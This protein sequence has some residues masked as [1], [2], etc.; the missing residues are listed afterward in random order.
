[1]ALM[2]V[3]LPVFG[4]F[5]RGADPLQLFRSGDSLRGLSAA[6]AV[7]AAVNLFTLGL[8]LL[9]AG[10]RQ[11][12]LRTSPLARRGVLAR[13]GAVNLML[14]GVAAI[15]LGEWGQDSNDWFIWWSF[16]PLLVLLLFVARVSVRRFLAAWKYDARSAEEASASDPRR[17]VLYLRSFSVDDQV[18]VPVGGRWRRLLALLNY[19][20]SV[21]PEQEMAFM[22]ARI[23]PVVAIGQPGER[24]PEL[25]AAR[26]YVGAD[27]WRRVVG[28]LMDAAALVVIRAGRR[29]TSGGKPRRRCAGCRPNGSS[30][31]RWSRREPSRLSIGA[32]RRPSA[33]RPHRRRHPGHG[34]S[35]PSSAC[36]F[37]AG[38]AKGRSSASTSRRGRTRCRSCIA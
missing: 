7:A 5:D 30:S 29:R 35:R 33:S 6:L 18:Q 21:S 10:L 26:R 9:L 16:L 20:A 2:A 3:A 14:L 24:L 1:M 25:G 4:A 36:C 34:G 11:L 32:S 12:S 17:P 22:L 38:T 8:V 19:A 37:R 27:D 15:A 28:E 31:W 23:G 13:M